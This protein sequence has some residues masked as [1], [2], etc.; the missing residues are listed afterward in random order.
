[1]IRRLYAEALGL[2]QNQGWGGGGKLLK[3]KPKANHFT[4]HLMLPP[5]KKMYIYYTNHTWTPSSGYQE[6]VDNHM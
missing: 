1:M 3:K 5:E 2:G 6:R 4:F